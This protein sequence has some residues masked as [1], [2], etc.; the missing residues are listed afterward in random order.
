MSLS[1]ANGTCTPN[2]NIIRTTQCSHSIENI[3]L[4]PLKY[5]IHDVRTP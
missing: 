2:D 4:R 5:K 1:I 3:K